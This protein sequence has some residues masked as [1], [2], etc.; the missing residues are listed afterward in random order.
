MLYFSKFKS[1]SILLICLLGIIFAF[2][3]LLSTST[4]NALPKIIPH[5]QINLGL[6]LR[7]GSHL[8]VEVQS[9]VRAT[10]RMDDLYDEI[11]IELRRNKILLSDISQ[12]NNQLKITLSDD[13]F[14]GDL[15]D[16]I[17]SLSQN[18]RGQLG[19]AELADELD[20]MEQIDGSILVSM[21]E[22]AKSDLLR[23]SV[24]QSIE[25]IRRRIDE[26]GTKEPTIQRQ[27]DSRILIQVPGLDDP[28]RLKDLLGTTAKMTFHLIDPFYDGGNV[29][30]SSMQLKHANNESTYVVERRSIIGGENLVDAQP[31]FDSQTNQPIVN[32]RFD[33]Q[34]SRKFGKITTDNVGKLF[35]IVLDNEV[36]SAP[37]IN[38]P[39]L[40]GSG[41]ISGSFTVQEANDLAILL[42]A[43]ALP[44]PLVILEERTVG[45]GLGADS[46]KS[47]QIASILGLLLVLIYMFVSYGRFGIYSNISLLINLSLIVAVL[48]ILQA[49]LTL[50]GIAG[51]ILT[52]G[53]AVDANVLIF[54]RIREE[55]SNKKSVINAIDNGYKRARTTILDANITTFIAA[56]ILFQLGSG[57][58]KGFSITLAIG[59]I[60]SVFTAFTLTRFL[61]AMWIKRSNPKEINI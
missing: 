40:G 47:G 8:L 48:S 7:G 16:I 56:I 35:A 51:I 53:M 27:G 25:I 29:S 3:N 41:M 36:I 4:L 10:E 55:I 6:D 15:L 54:E 49:T 24:D 31:G 37:I 46:I 23:R 18:V 21:T 17:E 12:S 34:G 5:K 26:L 58:I 19:T 50:P 28:K 38:E 22:E 42:R 13:G 43:G 20:I 30:R 57:P 39:I 52:I 45:P 59:I 32:F 44:A 9:S 61:V 60:T 14:K 2:P 1:I 11:R 33:G